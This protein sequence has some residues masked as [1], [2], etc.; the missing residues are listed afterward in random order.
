MWL[1]PQAA[2]LDLIYTDRQAYEAAG[3]AD[4][5]LHWTWAEMAAD[6]DR[7]ADGLPSVRPQW[8]Y[9]DAGLDSLY[10]YAFS[11]NNPCPQNGAVVCLAPVGSDSV[12]AALDWYRSMVVE[13]GYMPELARLDEDE[14]SF[15]ALNLVTPRKVAA[16]IDGP[17][18]YELHLLS[19]AIG[20][21]PFPGSERFDGITPLW[22]RGSFISE[23][24]RH[25]LAA[26]QWLKHLSYQYLAREKRTIPARPSIARATRFWSILPRPLSEAMRAAFPLA[27]PVMIDEQWLF[28]WEQ[29]AAV[30]SG[31]QSPQ[32]AALSHPRLRWFG[33]GTARG[34]GQGSPP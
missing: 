15:R 23:T 30:V 16:W 14:R 27:R 31:R 6:L 28:R 19:R 9:L 7:L 17:V 13:S 8:L 33:I 18:H 21:V 22:V 20:V 2:A 24:S 11:R 26:W 1:M 29:L 25:P 12:A 34:Q 5:S 4:P 10:A 32:E 3:L